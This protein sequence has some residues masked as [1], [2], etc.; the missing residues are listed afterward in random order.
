MSIAKW[1][2]FSEGLKYEG[3]E[4]PFF[5]V[6]SKDWA[7]LLCKNYEIISDEIQ[8]LISENDSGIIP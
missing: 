2:S 6:K 3:D 4:H 7:I 5:D 8:H 1:Y